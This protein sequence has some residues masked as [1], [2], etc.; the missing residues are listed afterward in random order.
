MFPRFLRTSC[1]QQIVL[2]RAP[3]WFRRK[4]PST[5]PSQ[6]A[7]YVP[8]AISSFSPMPL[9]PTGL[10]KRDEIVAIDLGA[11]ITK[12]VHLR[13][14]GA[15]YCLANYALI[16]TP[17]Y[18]KVPEQDDLAEHFRNVLRAVGAGTRRITVAIG[19]SESLL[20]HTELPAAPPA[21]LRKMIK[22]N[23]KAHVRQDLPD[24]VF[25]CYVPRAPADTLGTDSGKS[26]RSAQVLVGAV[27]RRWIETIQEAARTAGLVVEQITL[28]QVGAVN[29]FKMLPEESHA[30]VV[31]LLDLGFNTSAISIVSKGEFLLTRVV[32]IG[33]QKIGE[34]L[35][36]LAGGAQDS[37]GAPVEDMQ[38][39]LHRSIGMVAKELHASIQFFE[40]QHDL[41]VTQVL[42]SGGSARSQFILQNLEEELEIPCESWN[43]TKSLDLKLP[44]GK[45]NDLDYE[46]PQLIVA[47][48]A[49]LSYLNPRLITINLLA[50][51]QAVAEARRRDPVRRSVYAA[52]LVVL[53]ALAWAA[54]LGLR[55]WR[56]DTELKL[57]E[58]R[59]QAQ[60]KTAT[61]FMSTS[62]LA[63]EVE[64][65][66]A[67]LKE[68]GSNRFLWAPVLSALQFT[69]VPDI[70]F[71]ALKMEL[72]TESSGRPT[73]DTKQIQ[74]TERLL[75]TIKGKNYGDPK[76]LDKLVDSIASHPYFRVNLR[77][78]DPV[79]LR[80][81]QPQQ[82][83]SA[84]PTRKSIQFTI[85]CT[86]ADRILKHE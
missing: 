32:N 3:P 71:Q 37:Q 45:T 65:N 13:R 84:N 28:S 80:D 33:A 48:G 23:P 39:K 18:E 79:L 27:R 81:L 9:A 76:L 42:V 16:E 44:A 10:K 15:A 58:S 51:Q 19:T 43:P 7:I 38:I 52:A 21:E 72:S 50:E 30:E 67:A 46:A 25:D 8:A 41:K 1:R 4:S 17:P 70:E 86:F 64:R 73:P 20:S 29:A 68:L 61:Q 2:R 66:L 12:A 57:H 34:A 60:E 47:I 5:H 83:D 77:S 82:P 11:Q 24:C 62:R 26:R 63:A 59:K 35:S 75:M 74:V 55:L 78:T 53:M 6:L 14:H 56:T 69:T 85:E 49:G 31:A 36:K 54:Y 40:I 22:L